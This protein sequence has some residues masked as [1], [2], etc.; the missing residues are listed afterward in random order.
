M[1]LIAL[2]A[3][4]L[5]ASQ[6]FAPAPRYAEADVARLE[7]CVLDGDDM[8]RCGDFSEDVQALEICAARAD[9]SGGPESFVEKWSECDTA[10]PCQWEKP[11]PDQTTLMLRNC[12]ARGVAASRVITA[13]WLAQLDGQL[14]PEDR[15]LLAQVEKTTMDG[16]E[17]P[18][19]SDDPL[20]ASA[21]WSGSWASYLQFL[22]IAQLTGKAGL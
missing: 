17:L 2:T 12:S 22:R 21:H 4:V 3:A 20:R 6:T 13:R 15:A 1:S 8:A 14:S 18:A 19:A 5:L 10:L 9:L 16:L 11:E 7:G